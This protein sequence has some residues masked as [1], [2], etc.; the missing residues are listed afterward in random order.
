[1][2]GLFPPHYSLAG[3]ATTQGRGG[4]YAEAAPSSTNP[5]SADPESGDIPQVNILEWFPAYQSCQRFFLDHAQHEPNT[6]ALAAFLNIFLPFQWSS[7]PLS[8]STGIPATGPA[9]YIQPW[10]MRH[11]QTSTPIGQ[12]ALAFSLIPYIRRLVV[13][14]NDREAILHDLFGE[15]WKKGVG[16]LVEMERRN[17]LFA[18]KSVSWE[19]V[20]EHYDMSASETVPFLSPLRSVREEEIQIAENA[21]SRWLMMQDWLLGPRAPDVGDQHS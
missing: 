2:S 12:P 20:K 21:W 8:K 5:P 7:N 9:A 15:D 16:I 10:H 11:S 18:A 4:Y 19:K 14:G 1:M 17:Y 3:Y 6:Q 13:T